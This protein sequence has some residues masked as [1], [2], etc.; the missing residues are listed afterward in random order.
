M[1]SW[2]ST[3]QAETSTASSIGL[4]MSLGILA[5]GWTVPF[6]SFCAHPWEMTGWVSFTSLTVATST[7]DWIFGWIYYNLWWNLPFFL[8]DWCGRASCVCHTEEISLLLSQT[9][10]SWAHGENLGIRATPLLRQKLPSLS[11]A[12][13]RSPHAPVTCWDL[14]S[15]PPCS[16]T[17]WDHPALQKW[18]EI[19]TNQPPPFHQ[20]PGNLLHLPTP[21]TP[22]PLRKTLPVDVTTSCWFKQ[23]LTE[24]FISNSAAGRWRAGTKKPCRLGAPLQFAVPHP[25]WGSLAVD[26]LRE[27]PV[28]V[29]S[30]IW[31]HCRPRS[32]FPSLFSRLSKVINAWV[33]SLALAS[34]LCNSA[35]H[36]ELTFPQSI[37]WP[38]FNILTLYP[39]IPYLFAI[40]SL[41]P[42]QYLQFLLIQVH[43]GRQNYIPKAN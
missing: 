6:P 32:P 22:C 21:G 16:Q 18:S 30:T 5:S 13:P 23:L 2:F 4:S 41:P 26:P 24:K 7:L 42:W 1:Q 17:S 3:L 43:L 38:L 14:R 12:A 11:S 39:K 15:P 20:W 28:F 37:A 33:W 31:G 25:T 19:P 27:T 29:T 36:L 35:W 10:S 8:A 40:V 9:S 34:S